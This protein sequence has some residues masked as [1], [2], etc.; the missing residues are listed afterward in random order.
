M[1]IVFHL[2][3]GSFTTLES[4]DAVTI[5]F[6][7]QNLEQRYPD[8]CGILDPHSGGGVIFWKEIDAQEIDDSLD[9]G[10]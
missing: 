3:G 4:V 1:A 9:Y 10:E 7:Q 5:V 8:S 2:S 6:N